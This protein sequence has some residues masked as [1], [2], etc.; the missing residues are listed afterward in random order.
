MM[1][2]DTP[3]V[4]SERLYWMKSGHDAQYRDTIRNLLA[5]SLFALRIIGTLLGIIAA[6]LIVGLFR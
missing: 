2:D 4:M 1:P 6:V 5:D 3:F